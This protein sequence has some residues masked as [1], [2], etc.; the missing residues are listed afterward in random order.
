[1]LS[2]ECGKSVD[3]DDLLTCITCKAGESNT[4]SVPICAKCFVANH[5]GHQF[6]P[7]AKQEILSMNNQM[8]TFL[9]MNLKTYEVIIPTLS[10][11]VAELLEVIPKNCEDFEE[12]MQ[13]NVSYEKA[14]EKVA[15]CRELAKNYETI[16]EDFVPHLRGLEKKLQ[17]IVV[18]VE[19]LKTL[20]TE[21][22]K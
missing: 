1:M 13:A 8:S 20:G 2:C 7:A 17:Q 14:F 3:V 18:S 16:C 15:E 22:S 11:K 4:K 12:K 6:E 19:K 9:Q 5:N 10:E 21:S